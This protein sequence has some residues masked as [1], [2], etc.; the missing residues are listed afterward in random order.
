MA[1]VFKLLAWI[2]ITTVGMQDKNK[3]NDMKSKNYP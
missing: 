1:S 2:S 3:N